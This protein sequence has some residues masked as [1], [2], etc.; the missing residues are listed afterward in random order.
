MEMGRAGQ[1]GVHA[2]Y[3]IMARELFLGEE[4]LQSR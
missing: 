2:F 4:A 1:T 3:I